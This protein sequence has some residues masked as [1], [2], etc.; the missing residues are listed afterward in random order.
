MTRRRSWLIVLVIACALSPG[1]HGQGQPP[2]QPPPPPPATPDPAQPP[3]PT[4]KAGINFVRVDVIVSDKQGEVVQN[5]QQ[6]DFEVFEDGKPQAVESF[7]LIKIDGNPPPDAE[8]PRAIRTAF[9]EEREAA[10]DDVRLFAIFLDDYHVRRGTSMSVRDPLIRFISG[11]GANDLVAIMYPLMPVSDVRMTRDHESIIRAISNFWGRKWDYTPRNMFEEKYSN[12]PTE[13]VERIRNQVSL[14]AVEGLAAHLGGLREGR[15]AIILVSEGYS[16]YVPPQ[17]RDANASMP[18]FG[19]PNRNNPMAGENNPNEDRAA[20]FAGTDL[21]SDMR[22]VFNAANRANTAIYSL[23]PRGLS[24]GEYDIDHNISLRTSESM[25]SSTQDTLRVLADQTDGRAIVNRNDLA[26][27]L[28][29]VVRDSSAYYLLGYNSSQAPSDGK[30]HEIKVRVKKPG[31]Q[32]RARKGYWALTADET[33]RALAPAKPAPPAA[34]ENALASMAEPRGRAI[35]TWIG[36]SRGENGATKV[37]LVWEPVAQVSGASRDQATR[38]GVVAGSPDGAAYFRGKVP[39]VAL[40]STAPVTQ[41]APGGSVPR[42]PSR[43]VFDA[44]PGTLQLRLSVEGANAQV[45]D[46]DQRD[47]QVPDLTKAQ[48]MLSTPQVFR[49][50]TPREFQTIANDPDAV[51]IASREFRRTERLLIRLEVYGPGTSKPATR[52]T[53]LNRGGQKMSDVAVTAEPSGSL[54]IDLPLAGLAPGEYLLEIAAKDEGGEAKELI[55]MRIV[56]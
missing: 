56:S 36:M 39:D 45:I 25:L 42:T 30:F 38:V 11:L 4:F 13:T 47:V 7:K 21:L 19:N 17:L 32:V 43:V 50:A 40:A 31:L 27:G 28:Q 44:K 41:A 9:D 34:V 23:D 6:N 12:Y 46:T 1:V 3:K 24:G 14:S 37:T 22:E 33:A 20:F 26:K 8:P 48:V 35:R 10:R 16:N 2:A 15:K 5:L 54:R 18:G 49:A 53:L 52:A 55:P 29:Q 51:P